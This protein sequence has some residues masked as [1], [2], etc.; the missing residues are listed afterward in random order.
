MPGSLLGFKDKSEMFFVLKKLSLI[1]N[2]EKK[3]AI[4]V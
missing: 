4:M 1:G 2:S 3:S